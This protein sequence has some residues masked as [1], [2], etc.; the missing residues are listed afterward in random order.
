MHFV[1]EWPSAV[2][3]SKCSS[4]KGSA[5][6][7]IERDRDDWLHKEIFKFNISKFTKLHGS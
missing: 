6:I 1:H 2:P 3:Q 7:D 5:E 4:C